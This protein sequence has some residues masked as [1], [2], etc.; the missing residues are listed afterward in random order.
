M[1]NA[2]TE[3]K[4]AEVAER[5]A[6]KYQPERIILF[7]SW[8]WGKPDK[9]SDIDLFIVKET[10]KNIFERNREV[11]KIIFDSGV[12][13]DV[14]VYTKEQLEKRKKMGDPFIWKI[15]NNGKNLYGTG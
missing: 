9:N 6:K 5:I 13:T 14:L 12:A 4:I 2:I 10:S 8:A 15:I 3:Q 7:G 1:E 11:A